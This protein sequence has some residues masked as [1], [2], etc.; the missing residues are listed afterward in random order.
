MILHFILWLKLCLLKLPPILKK[1][2]NSKR[3]LKTVAIEVSWQIL[4]GPCPVVQTEIPAASSRSPHS[5]T[6]TST[7]VRKLDAY[8]SGSYL[9]SG[10]HL[11][12][13]AIYALLLPSSGQL[14]DTFNLWKPNVTFKMK[15]QKLNTGLGSKTGKIREASKLSYTEEDKTSFYFKWFFI[16]FNHWNC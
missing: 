1:K 8:F 5:N 3:N 4:K 14:W 11:F 2:S 10:L 12:L 13:L 9:L 7:M 15:N 6:I 16:P